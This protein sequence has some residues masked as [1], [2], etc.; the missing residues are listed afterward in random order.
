MNKPGVVLIT[1]LLIVM[2]MSVLSMQISKNFL[3]SLKRENFMD[4][5]NVSYHL[6]LSAESMAIGKL[7]KEMSQYSKKLTKIDPL[8]QNNIYFDIDSVNLEIGFS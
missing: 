8:L 7:K 4:F 5:S 3:L 2:I 6:L 1:T